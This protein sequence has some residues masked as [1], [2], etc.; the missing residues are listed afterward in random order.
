MNKIYNVLQREPAL[1]LAVIQAGIALAVGL[2]FHPKPGVTGGVLAVASALMG[3][4]VAIHVH[5]VTAAIVTGLLSAAGTLGAA[6]GV[7][8][9]TSGTVSLVNGL[10]VALFALILSA[11]AT[12]RASAIKVMQN[13]SAPSRP[14]G[15]PLR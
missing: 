4:V 9:I 5:E 2:G 6:F 7:P 11:R 14:Q 13:V 3:L 10:V 12:P 1:V 8:H 15:T